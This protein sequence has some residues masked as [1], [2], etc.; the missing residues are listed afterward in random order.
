[1]QEDEDRN[2]RGAVEN[3]RVHERGAE[4][5]SGDRGARAKIDERSTG[6]NSEAVSPGRLGLGREDL[7]DGK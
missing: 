3:H 4:Q 6:A 5:A 7:G 2:C 1:M